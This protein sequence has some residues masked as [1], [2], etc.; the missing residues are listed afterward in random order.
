MEDIKKRTIEYLKNRQRILF[1]TCSNRWEKHQD[2]PKSTALAY[3]MAIKIGSDKV[4]VIEVPKLRIYPCEGNVSAKGGN[5]CGVAA[6]SLPDK[7]KNPTGNLRCWASYN[8]PDDELYKIANEIF[9]ADT[10]VFFASVR[11]GQANMFYQKLIERLCWIENRWASLGESNLLQ[12][13]EAGFIC[14]GQNFNGENVVNTQMQVLNFY[15]FD[16]PNDLFWNWQFTKD[17]YDE[18][19]SSYQKAISV[20]QKVFNISMEKFVEKYKKIKE[21]FSPKK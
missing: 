8:N 12:G 7:E 13:K 19:L 3:D 6:S 9:A 14:I 17:E 4:K 11:W 1:L 20:F 2:E 18:S 15:G 21:M 10:V 5:N 16:T